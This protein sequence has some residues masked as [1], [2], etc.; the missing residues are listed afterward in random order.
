VR[1]APKTNL[2]YEGGTETV[3]LAEDDLAVRNMTASVLRNFGYGVIE[4]ADG[5]EA[6]EKF[7]E[8]RD[9]VQLLLLDVMMPKKN[10]QE[11]Y[12]EIRKLEPGIRALFTSGY[13]PE[14]VL[15]KRVL[16]EGANFVMKPVS[17]EALLKKVREVLDK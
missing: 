16:L 2:A 1:P 3:L 10:G 15:N 13:T 17:P 8:Y 12:E 6:V 5:Q 14:T 7:L 9:V 4:A 11:V